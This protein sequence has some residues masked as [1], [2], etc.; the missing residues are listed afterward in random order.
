MATLA[1]DLGVATPDT[2]EIQGAEVV[3]NAVRNLLKE[4]RVEVPADHRVGDEVLDAWISTAM[5]YARYEPN[6]PR[7]ITAEEMKTMLRRVFA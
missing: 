3:V 6:Y 2:D 1:A 5:E 7:E 4:L